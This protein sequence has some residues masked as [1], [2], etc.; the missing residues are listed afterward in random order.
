MNRTFKAAVA[1][2]VLAV[3]FAGFA[4]A[5]CLKAAERGVARPPLAMPNMP[6][7]EEEAVAYFEREAE[8]GDSVMQFVLGSSYLNG[9]GVPQDY[10][11]AM[12]WFRKAADQGD[13]WAQL[14]V[15]ELYLTGNGVPQDYVQAHMWFNLAAASSS[16]LP[17]WRS[18]YGVHEDAVRERDLVASKMTRA[19][20]AEAQKLAREWKPK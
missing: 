4:V 11:E 14:N 2:L 8:Q 5:E 1:A 10:R 13:Y 17:S 15:G 18:S 16:S 20:I 7:T 9:K 6:K 3:S 12:K 19:Q